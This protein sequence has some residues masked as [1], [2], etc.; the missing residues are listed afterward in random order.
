MLEKLTMDETS[1]P[2]ILI[3]TD[4]LPA[5]ADFCIQGSF[6]TFRLVADPITYAVMGKSVET[7]LNAA[8]MTGAV[9]IL[10]GFPLS[11]GGDA[12]LQLLTHAFPL[13]DVFLAVGSGTVT[14]VV[15]F[16]SRCLNR[17]FIS[18]PT[19][20][21]VDGYTS[22]TSPLIVSQV[23][24]SYPGQ[25]P[26]AVFADLPT[27]C[28]APAEMIAAGFGDMLGKATALA[29]WRLGHLLAAE[30]IDEDIAQN[31]H[32]DLQ[33]CIAALPGIT[34]RD[35]Q[36][37][38][39]LMESQVD[40]GLNMA[41]AGSSR[42]ASGAEHHLAHYWEMK[43]MWEGRPPLLHGIKVGFGALLVADCYAQLRSVTLARLQE[44]LEQGSAPDRQSS[45]EEIRRFYGDHSN[46]II[47]EQESYLGLGEMGWTRFKALL[48]ERWEDVLVIARSVPSRAELEGHLDALHF[49]LSA[50]TLN[51]SETDVSAALRAAHYLRDR[52]TIL[53]LA[54]LIP[55]L[56]AP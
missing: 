47:A 52:M 3:G 2:L 9:T 48:C 20:P 51:L 55:G 26:L 12:V 41:R 28:A 33:R 50:A 44:L 42:P 56:V 29:D 10:A 1:L 16:T 34:A 54:W 30:P 35:P 21:S 25:L 13:P 31:A 40:S 37:I 43:M 49:P 17:P 22:P 15:R 23:K 38:R 19:A 24:Q 32:A 6:K 39:I 4:T 45:I 46:R 27:L 8:G 36:G 18:V 11:A 53:Q 5:L 7:T 14:D